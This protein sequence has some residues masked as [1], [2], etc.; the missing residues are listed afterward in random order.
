MDRPLLSVLEI[1]VVKLPIKKMMPFF[2]ARLGPHSNTLRAMACLGFPASPRQ[3]WM[4][5]CSSWF[6]GGELRIG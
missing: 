3:T 2:V 5:M 4:G 6:R 1:R